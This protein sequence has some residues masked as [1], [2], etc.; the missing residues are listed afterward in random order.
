MGDQSQDLFDAVMA[1]PK[2]E[3]ALL[4]ERLLDAL[5]DEDEEL[6]DDEL[7]AE[8]DRRLAEYHR[9]PSIGIPWS[10]V[11]RNLVRRMGPNRTTTGTKR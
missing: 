10:E 3:R 7:A 4:V 11:N 5:S 8:L 6:T 9:D 1:L 2:T